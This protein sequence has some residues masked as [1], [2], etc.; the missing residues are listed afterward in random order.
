MHLRTVS[1]KYISDNLVLEL[2]KLSWGPTK[3]FYQSG[4][5]FYYKIVGLEG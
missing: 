2:S 5:I 4:S 1:M 3:L